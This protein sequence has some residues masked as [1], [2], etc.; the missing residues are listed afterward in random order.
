MPERKNLLLYPPLTDPTAPYHSPSYLKGHAASRGFTAIDIRDT[1]IEGFHHAVKLRN[2]HRLIQHIHAR[3]ARL[4][5]QYELT[6]DE[7]QE[8]ALLLCERVWSHERLSK[9]IRDLQRADAFYDYS[10]YRSAVGQIRL[11]MRLLSC[12]GFPGQFDGFDLQSGLGFD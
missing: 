6:D 11:W 3:R 10:R 7:Q 9:A 5:S 8:L 1:N 2:A 12:L 4:Q